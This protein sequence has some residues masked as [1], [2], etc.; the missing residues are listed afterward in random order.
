MMNYILRMLAALSIMVLFGSCRAIMMKRAI[1]DPVVETRASISQFITSNGFNP[2]NQFVLD[3]DSSS[4]FLRMFEYSSAG[5]MIFDSTGRA[6]CFNGSSTCSGIII[7]SLLSGK[8][9]LFDICPDV[10]PI[11]SLLLNVT[12]LDNG[13]RTERSALPAA[14]YYLVEYWQK[15]MGGRKGYKHGIS[16][17]DNKLKV[18]RNFR[19]VYLKINTDMRDEWGLTAGKKMSIKKKSRGGSVMIGE[20]GP[21]PSK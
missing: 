7:D 17:L 4:A 19:V 15:F 16:W 14:D 10:D 20:F 2:D 5:T 1:R 3:G 8:G 13:S 18:Q 21:P 6:L 11:D 9:Y 12:R